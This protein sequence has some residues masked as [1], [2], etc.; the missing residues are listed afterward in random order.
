LNDTNI[1]FVIGGRFYSQNETLKRFTSDID[2][3]IS[4]AVSTI[5]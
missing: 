2:N 5:D 4:Y 3:V 1:L